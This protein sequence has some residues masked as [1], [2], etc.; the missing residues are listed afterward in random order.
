MMDVFLKFDCIGP[1]SLSQ[2]QFSILS[3][4]LSLELSLILNPAL[5]WVLSVLPS[6]TTQHDLISALH[7]MYLAMILASSHLSNLLPSPKGEAAHWQNRTFDKDINEMKEDLEGFRLAMSKMDTHYKALAFESQRALAYS[8]L[9]LG[10]RLR[11]KVQTRQEEAAASIL[12]AT[13]QDRVPSAAEETYI[14]LLG[15]LIFRARMSVI[16]GFQEA[17]Q[18]PPAKDILAEEGDDQIEDEKSEEDDNVESA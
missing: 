8:L 17:D 3:L 12:K 11:D 10:P 13:P 7:A 18:I 5:P 15:R 4:L 9:P 16:P 2:W 14:H 1:L 6:Q